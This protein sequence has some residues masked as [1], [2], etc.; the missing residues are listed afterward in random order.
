M[1][2]LLS[3]PSYPPPGEGPVE[4]FLERCLFAGLC[5]VMLTYGV[6]L[7]ITIGCLYLM[8]CHPLNGRRRWSLIL[9]IL[10]LFCGATV[11]MVTNYAWSQLIFIDARAFPGGPPA[12]FATQFGIWVNTVSNSALTVNNLMVSSLVLWRCFVI[13]NYNK[14]VVLVPFLTLIA[15]AVMGVLTIK[16]SVE[17]GTTPWLARGFAIPYFSLCLGLNILLTTLIVS[18]LLYMRT[19]VR[20]LGKQHARVYSSLAAVI[21]DSALPYTLV[22]A[23]VIVTLTMD[24]NAYVNYS[25]TFAVPMLGGVE[26]IVSMLI[27]L[28]AAFGRGFQPESNLKPE[29]SG[30]DFWSPSRPMST[31]ITPGAMNPDYQDSTL[32]LDRKRRSAAQ[33]HTIRPPPPSTLEMYDME[34]QQQQQQ[35]QYTTKQQ[36]QQRVR[37]ESEDQEQEQEEPSSPRPYHLPLRVDRRPDFVRSMRS[38]PDLHTQFDRRQR[39]DSDTPLFPLGLSQGARS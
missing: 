3:F 14:L 36:Q 23:L 17:P 24:E 2:V 16:Q 15:T 18:R 35:Q 38:A 13:W 7:T 39:Y 34:Q 20:G 1:S 11:F 25:S 22:S 6:Y 37:Y 31:M 21:V 26:W 33:V 12:F 4:L 27:L 32:N 8:L 5:I 9:Y 29:P 10:M 19:K 30:L 28:R